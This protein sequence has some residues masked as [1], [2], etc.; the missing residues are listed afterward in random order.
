MH[1]LQA[2]LEILVGHGGGGRRASVGNGKGNGTHKRARRGSGKD[3]QAKL[4]E[5]LKS[6]KNGLSLAELADKTGASKE[7]VGYHLRVLRDGKKAK[8]SGTR[9]SARWHA[10]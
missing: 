8:L 9:N 1:R 7:T 6:A 5:T 10:A 4:Q 2:T 3:M